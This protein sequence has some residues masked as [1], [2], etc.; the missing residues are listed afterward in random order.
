MMPSL[1]GKHQRAASDPTEMR[2]AKQP[3]PAPLKFH[4]ATEA[5][6]PSK[7]KATVDVQPQ[8]GSTGYLLTTD[9]WFPRRTLALYVGK[10]RTEFLVHEHLIPPEIIRAMSSSSP[11]GVTEIYLEDEEP[12]VVGLMVRWCYRGKF[13]TFRGR[14]AAPKVEDNFTNTPGPS[15][16][17]TDS[18]ES[19]PE[20]YQTLRIYFEACNSEGVQEIISFEEKRLNM[21]NNNAKISTIRNYL[22]DVEGIP[23]LEQSNEQ[24]RAE[25]LQLKFVRLSQMAVKYGW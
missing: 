7:P 16:P 4:S 17:D 6:V 3:K 10:G 22:Q 24:V 8:I 1:L 15:V 20:K 9:L 11:E 18:G 13:P 19:C 23:M 12:D 14:Q 21:Y 2:L 5:G 25:L